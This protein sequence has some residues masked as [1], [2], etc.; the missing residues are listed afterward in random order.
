MNVSSIFGVVGGF[1]GSIAYH[2][3]KGAI[4]TMTKNAAPRHAKEG[5][6]VNSIHPGFI[7]TPMLAGIEGT[8]LEQEILAATPMGRLARPEEIADAIVFLAGDRA[9]YVTGAALLADGGWTAR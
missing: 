2:A 7:E 1:G 6:G 5:T 9:S 4:R 8:P 3:A